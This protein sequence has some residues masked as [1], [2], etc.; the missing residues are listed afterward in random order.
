MMPLQLMNNLDIN[1]EFVIV[2][3][4]NDVVAA[5]ADTPLT[6][7]ALGMNREQKGC[8]ADPHVRIINRGFDRIHRETWRYVAGLHLNSQDAR[9]FGIHPYGAFV[10]RNEGLRA[11]IHPPV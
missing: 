7:Q 1:F 6:T 10:S 4:V 9:G 5:V 3:E 2:A 11:D 8:S